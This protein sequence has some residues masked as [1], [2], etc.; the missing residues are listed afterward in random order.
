MNNEV[1]E[2]PD[3]WVVVKDG[4][5]IATH[6]EPAHLDGTQAVRYVPAQQPTNCR[7]CGGADNVICAGQCKVQPV[8][9]QQEPFIPAAWT[10]IT[11]YILQDDL[12]NRLT[13][14]VVDIAYSAFMIGRSGKNKDD[15]G[16]CDWFNDTKP[17]V[18]EQLAKIR[19]D[20]AEQP[21]QQQEPIGHV[22]VKTH[23]AGNIVDFEFNF[24]AAEQLSE[25][26]HPAYTTPQPPAQRKPLTDDE[27]D[28]LRR[29]TPPY[30][31]VDFD[32]RCRDFARAIEAAY[33]IF[34]DE[35]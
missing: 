24:D 34:K 9:V 14:R 33:G 27:I 25:G 32:V 35:K 8:P 1:M 3:C 31:G 21:A 22:I 16:P 23:S 2:M 7:H 28:A 6:N 18:M 19:K 5:I 13:P 29:K 17:M 4:Q 26:K 30:A 12:H 20:L 10:D 15:G 11:A